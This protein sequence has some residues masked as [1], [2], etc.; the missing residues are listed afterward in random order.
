M[1]TFVALPSLVLL[2]YSLTIFRESTIGIFFGQTYV[3]RKNSLIFHLNV[4]TI[5][6]S[7]SSTEMQQTFQV[8]NEGFSPET[9]LSF[10]NVLF[11]GSL[12][13]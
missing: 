8:L 11:R 9:S 2:L 5:K 13:M 6:T 4:V 1:A 3:F 12:P 7:S 10:K